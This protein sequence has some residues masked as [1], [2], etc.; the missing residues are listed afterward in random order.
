MV[1][2]LDH[3]SNEPFPQVAP[4]VWLDARVPRNSYDQAPFGFEVSLQSANTSKVM[5]SAAQAE[6]AST[7][8]VAKPTTAASPS[9]RPR[10]DPW[11]DRRHNE[12]NAPDDMPPRFAE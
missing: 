3:P 7:A 1:V 4:V 11:V 12:N 9:M 8:P 6:G 5:T 10:H 2:T